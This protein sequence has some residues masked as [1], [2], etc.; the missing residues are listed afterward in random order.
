MNLV[1]GVVSALNT[2]ISTK[3]YRCCFCL[4][5]TKFPLNFRCCSYLK[6]IHFH[7][8]C[9]CSLNTLN[10]RYHAIKP[11]TPPLRVASGDPNFDRRGGFEILK[12]ENPK[13]GGGVLRFFKIFRKL[14]RGF[15]IFQNS[16]KYSK[17]FA[18]AARDLT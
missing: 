13:H 10:Y 1:S 14:K 9:W 3:N 16:R 5:Y 2:L 8:N 17:F 11:K 4:K 18:P 15:E 12:N 7:L 6:Y